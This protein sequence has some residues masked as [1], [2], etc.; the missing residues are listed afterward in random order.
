MT[1]PPDLARALASLHQWLE[2]HGFVPDDIHIIIEV[3]DH[4]AVND[5]ANAI[6]RDFEHGG[7]DATQICVLSRTDHG[8]DGK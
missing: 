1:Q 5:L 4:A 7:I 2:Y 8:T 3:P 6:Q